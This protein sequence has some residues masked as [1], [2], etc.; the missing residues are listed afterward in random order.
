MADPAFARRYGDAGGV[1]VIGAG[2]AG[3]SAAA[4]LAR[5]KSAGWLIAGSAVIA[6]VMLFVLR[7]N[8][9][10]VV[11]LVH[12]IRFPRVAGLVEN[13]S[14]GL[15]FLTNARSLAVVMFHSAA[16]WFAIA[17]QFWFML[18]GMN[19]DFAFGAATLVMVAAAIGSI[20]QIPGIGGGFQVAWRPWQRRRRARRPAG[21]LK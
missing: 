9:E 4:M 17:L 2:F 21:V 18:F 5:L 1:I 7:A 6:I 11:R 8:S 16:L 19:L 20:A 12:Y 10:A 13:F 3:L 15:G 14:R